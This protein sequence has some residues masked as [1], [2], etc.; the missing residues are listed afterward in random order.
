VERG[1]VLPVDAVEQLP[2]TGT[3]PFFV[4]CGGL[5]VS[6]RKEMGLDGD[7]PRRPDS[8]LANPNALVGS[9]RPIVL[10]AEA[11]DMVDWE[12]EL[13]LV[14]G[15]PTSR[16][17]PE[18]ALDHVAGYTI[19]NDVSAR[20]NV[21]DLFSTDARTAVAGY[22]ANVLY[23]AF[24][25]FGPLGPWIVT[26]DELPDVAEARLRTTVNG[27]LMQDELVGGLTASIAE[28]VAAV[29]EVYSFG[30]GDILSLG[31]PAGVGYARTPQVF[32]RPGDVVE[33]SVEGIGTL[34]NPV[35][36][37]DEPA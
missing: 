12:G 15:R 24:P 2:P 28:V 7:P 8:Y 23:K 19:Y 9:G 11:P 26:R 37:S 21:P 31:T 14:F 32:L 25:T 10:P 30:V 13:C 22:V 18:T 5:Y 34:S 29:T 36:A 6:H 20:D 3:T 35:V 16:V 4:A 1:W 17:D 33:V 27:Q